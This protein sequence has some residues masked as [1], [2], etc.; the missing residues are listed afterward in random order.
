MK[1]AAAALAFGL[2]LS[3]Q[4]AS[5]ADPTIDA[6]TQETLRASMTTIRETLPESRRQE[7][8]NAVRGALA[9]YVSPGDNMF[10]AISALAELAK[11]NEKMIAAMRASVGGKTAA[12]LFAMA[13]ARKKERALGKIREAEAAVKKAEAELEALVAEDKKAEQL[14]ST[15][16]VSA[17]VFKWKKN[18]YSFD[19]SISFKLSNRSNNAI[20]RFYMRGT[21]FTAGRSVPWVVENFNYSVPGGIEPKEEPTYTLTPGLA[22][23]W[24]RVPQDRNDLSMQI[25]VTGADDAKGVSIARREIQNIEK[26]KTRLAE[27]QKKLADLKASIPN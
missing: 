10:A 3:P 5:A 20:S 26:A 11:D 4:A 18:S 16:V 15:L 14:L 22:G 17:P 9:D 23:E 21:V 13:D 7:F 12:E 24:S 1:I 25:V 6:S 19:P 2:L 27:E 8:D